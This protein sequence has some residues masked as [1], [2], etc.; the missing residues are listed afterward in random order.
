LISLRME[1]GNPVAQQRLAALDGPGGN[2]APEVK[3][4]GWSLFKR[5]K[6]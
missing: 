5:T 3:K 2:A 4:R 6:E 1:P